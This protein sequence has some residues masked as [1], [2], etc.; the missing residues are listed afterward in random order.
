[1]QI[2]VHVH[3]LCKIKHSGKLLYLV[4]SPVYHINVKYAAL[5]AYF[6]N[7]GPIKSRKYACR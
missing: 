5:Q 7:I 4:K 6:S 2:E 1:M 3:E